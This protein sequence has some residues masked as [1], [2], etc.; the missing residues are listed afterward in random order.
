M[1]DPV[2]DLFTRLKN[3]ITRKSEIVDIP[4]SKLKEEIVKVLIEE[5]FIVKYEV[6]TKGNKKIL[7]V[8]LKYAPDRYGKLVNS[9]ITSIRQVS[10]PGKRIYKTRKDIPVV[11][12]GFGICILSTPQGVMSGGEAKKKKVGGEVIG[13]VY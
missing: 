13:Y 8:S 12:S 5:G 3:S 7:R 4:S 10:K 6:V 2:S 11:Q 1:K 9:V